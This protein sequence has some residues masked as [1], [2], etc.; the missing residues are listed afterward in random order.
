MVC[1]FVFLCVSV[2]VCVCVRVSVSVR[3]CIHPG[4]CLR[5]QPDLNLIGL[6]PWC[7]SRSVSTDKIS[8]LSLSRVSI[9][10]IMGTGDQ[11]KPLFPSR[12]LGWDLHRLV[13]WCVVVTPRSA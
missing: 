5:P 8:I 12:W 10:E 2:C 11:K 3:C 1:V 6:Y 9:C 7:L 4:I 13:F